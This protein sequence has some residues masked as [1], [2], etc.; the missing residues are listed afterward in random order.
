MLTPR[1][2]EL[3]N[4]LIFVV[5]ISTLLGFFAG[6][7]QALALLSS[8]PAGIFRGGF[9]G[10][11]AGFTIGSVELILDRG[12]LMW[13]IRRIPIIWVQ[14]IRLLIFLVSLGGA[15]LFS[16]WLT[17]Q[18]FQE[19]RTIPFWNL[20]GS[21]FVLA[22]TL[23]VLVLP[24]FK[25]MQLLSLRTLF[26]ASMGKYL[27]PSTQNLGILF[28]DLKGSTAIIESIGDKDFLRYLNQILFSISGIILEHRGEIYRYVGDEFII[29]WSEE[30]VQNSLSCVTEIQRA[31]ARDAA[32]FR[33]RFNVEP[34]FRFGL[35]F[36]EVLVGEIG[37]LRSEI[38][39]IGDAVNTAKRIEDVCRHFEFSTLASEAYLEQ[40][41][42]PEDVRAVPVE[43]IKLRGKAK[44][45]QLYG[46]AKRLM[47]LGETVQ[48]SA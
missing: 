12:P 9:L 35:H 33:K 30:H 41:D 44:P 10:I 21:S 37:D 2:K 47:P 20:F 46:V 8:I 39:L 6:F 1:E 26:R 36:G 48:L 43:A 13:S 18:L 32:S 3:K 40:V 15:S 24:M 28:M 31:L 17:P 16:V 22:V 29:T 5:G 7:G 14:T 38:A 23:G 4:R 19:S 25:I 34:S 42:M 11:I 27:H 45:L